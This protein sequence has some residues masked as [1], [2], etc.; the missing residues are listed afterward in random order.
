MKITINELKTLVRKVVK[1]IN[2]APFAGVE[3]MISTRTPERQEIYDNLEKNYNY[4]SLGRTSNPKAIDRFHRTSFYQRKANWAFAGFDMP[5]YI[6]PFIKERE[7]FRR[8]NARMK[9]ISKDEFVDIVKESGQEIDVEKVF[10]NLDSGACY[11]LSRTN[12]LSKG[13][14][15]TPWMILHALFDD[16]MVSFSAYQSFN[17]P[18]S[19]NIIY[20]FKIW[21]L[22]QITKFQVNLY[23]KYTYKSLNDDNYQKIIKQLQEFY[24]R[25]NLKNVNQYTGPQDFVAEIMTQEIATMN[26]FQVKMLGNEN[27]KFWQNILDKIKSLNLKKLMAD[28]F[29]G[30]IIQINTSI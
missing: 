9:F 3:P 21:L 28:S 26:G 15:P 19:L 4:D 12:Y 17:F 20:K 1:Q 5:V 25:T 11:I 16:Q 22:N 10:S 8:R 23:K 7:N 2:E 14:L 30:Q 6:I 24:E 18:D 13:F 29:K 27:D